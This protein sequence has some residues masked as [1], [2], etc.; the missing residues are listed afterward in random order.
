ME[1]LMSKSVEYMLTEK[2]LELQQSIMPELRDMGRDRVKTPTL[3]GLGQV[4]LYELGSAVTV[5]A[6]LW[7]E[8]ELDEN[9][10]LFVEVESVIYRIEIRKGEAMVREKDSGDLITDHDT[11]FKITSGIIFA[12]GVR[13]FQEQRFEEETNKVLQ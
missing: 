11:L 6:R 7:N 8:S 13:L 1:P 5:D 9:G 3:A 12:R 4:A 10:T 2:S